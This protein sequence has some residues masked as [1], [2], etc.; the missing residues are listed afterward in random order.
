ML[1]PVALDQD[2]AVVLEVRAGEVDL[3]DAKVVLVSSQNDVEY[4][5][6]KAECSDTSA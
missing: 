3:K 4:S 5:I 2:P 6:H 1:I